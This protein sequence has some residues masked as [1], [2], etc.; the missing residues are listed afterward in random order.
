MTHSTKSIHLKNK[1]TILIVSMIFVVIFSALA[2][3]MA[4]MSG[5]NLQIAENQHKA[6]SARI[7]AESGLEVLRF[8][9]S[10]VSIS[11]TTADEMKFSQIAGSLQQDL[12][13]QS[14]T[15]VTTSYDG[16]TVTIPS[17][18]LDSQTQKSFH[19]K[20]TKINNNLQLDITGVCGTFTRTIRTDY[21][22]GERANNVFDFGVATR[23]PLTTQGNVSIAGV[24][25]AVESNA[26]IESLSSFVALTMSG[27]SNI[28]G[29]VKIVNPL[30]T[31]DIGSKAGVGG[32]TGAD[33]MKNIEIG[34]PPVEF[35]EMV[36]SIFYSYA[37]NVLTPSTNLK[38]ATLTNIRI[39]GGMNPVFSGQANLNGVVL[40]ESPNVVEFSGGVNITGVIVTNG[41]PTDDSG[42]NQLIFRGNVADYSVE[43]LPDE[44]QFAGLRSQTG[45]FIIAPG[46]AVS[47]GGTMDTSG[48]IAANGVEFFG[49]AGGKIKG[50]VIN[51]ADKDM[52]VWGNSDLYFNRSGITEVPAGFVPQ[53][54]LVYEP[55]S[56]TEV[57]L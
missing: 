32:D 17:V 3:S 50:S 5:T 38:N 34:A 52:M 11:G 10:R 27:N 1:G 46:F 40:I 57:A 42:T 24:N 7:C 19:G 16:T 56:Y 44:P 33:A 29:T 53:I 2:V 48:A 12:T 21:K 22:L 18:T 39:P 47:F 13:S 14:I 9:L 54:V 25:I 8:W 23:G 35:P 51:Y 43:S 6:D 55:S 36:P 30:A 31:V 15:N 26:Y 28:A 45:T 4:T 20:I 37:T 49:N 41:D